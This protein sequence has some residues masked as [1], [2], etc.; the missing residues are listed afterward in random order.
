[1]PLDPRQP[2]LPGVTVMLDGR[3]F[4]VPSLLVRKLR[5][6]TESGRVATLEATGGLPSVDQID[7]VLEL[8]HA[9][10]VRNYPGITLE[11]VTGL[12]DMAAMPALMRAIFMASGIEPTSAQPGGAPGP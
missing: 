5:E 10:L 2:L 6:V 12:V 1:M 11:E 3:P 8:A 7:L 9:A 4:V